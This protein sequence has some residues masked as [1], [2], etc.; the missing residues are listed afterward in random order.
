[1][2][3]KGKRDKDKSRKQK[4]K[5]HEQAVKIALA[6]QP[7]KAPLMKSAR[8]IKRPNGVLDPL[9]FGWNRGRPSKYVLILE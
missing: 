4:Q 6:K 1:M 2:G 9:A 3:D 7:A 8:T 5:K